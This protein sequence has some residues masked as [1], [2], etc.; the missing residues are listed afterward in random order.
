MMTASA[1]VQQLHVTGKGLLSGIP[2]PGAIY[3]HA[4]LCRRAALAT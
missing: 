1:Q 4:S 3:I 2:G